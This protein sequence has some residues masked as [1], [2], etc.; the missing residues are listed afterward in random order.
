MV[1]EQGIK[2]ERKKHRKREKGKKFEKAGSEVEW[3]S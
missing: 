3:M 2:K 1:T